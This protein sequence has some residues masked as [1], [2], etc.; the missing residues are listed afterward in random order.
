ME[1][2][3]R[4]TATGAVEK[5]GGR[6]YLQVTCTCGTVKFVQESKLRSGHTKSCGCLQREAASKATLRHGQSSSQAYRAWQSMKDRCTNPKNRD[7]KDYGGRGITFDPRWSD[8]VNF[9]ADMGEPPEGL[10]L[11]RKDNNLGYCKANC[12]WATRE[13]QGNNRRSNVFVEH[14]GLAYRLQ[15]IADLHKVTYDAILKRRINGWTA[16]QLV[17]GHR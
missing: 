17:Q 15:E 6:S 14:G 11:D 8:P 12:R 4:L 5:R 16:A 7:F 10:S 3:G 2:F 9:L 1:I 13:E